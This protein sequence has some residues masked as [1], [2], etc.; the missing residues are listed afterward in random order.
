MNVKVRN[1]VTS[2]ANLSKDSHSFLDFQK[3]W[4]HKVKVVNLKE[5]RDSFD[6]CSNFKIDKDKIELP[7]IYS[8]FSSTFSSNF[9][10]LFCFGSTGV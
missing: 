4:W 2:D 3:V 8:K 7:F 5:E 6:I 10:Y 9:I 1:L